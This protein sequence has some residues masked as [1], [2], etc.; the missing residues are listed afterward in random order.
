ML[1]LKSIKKTLI[2]LK[3]SD[4]LMKKAIPKA[5]IRQIIDVIWSF[6][7]VDSRELDSNKCE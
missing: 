3:I 4:S 6:G 5:E 2:G 7:L 1:G